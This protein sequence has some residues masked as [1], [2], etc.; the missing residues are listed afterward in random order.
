MSVNFFQA[1]SVLVDGVVYLPPLMTTIGSN[2]YPVCVSCLLNEKIT[3]PEAWVASALVCA[4]CVGHP[5]QGI[6]T[7][8]RA[9]VSIK[10]TVF[11]D[12]MLS[13]P[14]IGI[15]MD[16]LFGILIADY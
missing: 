10:K 8:V 5:D 13:G 1:F 15:G 6:T 4:A 3:V 16:G 11:E 14:S 7:R 12:R 9:N 2:K